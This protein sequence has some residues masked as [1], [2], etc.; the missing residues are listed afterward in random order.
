[1]FKSSVLA[2]SIIAMIILGI[3]MEKVA[4]NG[5]EGGRCGFYKG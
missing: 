4:A 3:M 5:C 2:V 1:M